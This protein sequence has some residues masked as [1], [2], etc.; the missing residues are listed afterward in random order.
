MLF[1]FIKTKKLNINSL[2]P[3]IRNKVQKFKKIDFSNIYCVKSSVKIVGRFNLKLIRNSFQHCKYD[4]VIRRFKSEIP[5]AE[6][7]PYNGVYNFSENQLL[8][9]R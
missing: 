8:A 4:Y 6:K 1:T 3:Y 5:L 7:Y 9:A 2:N